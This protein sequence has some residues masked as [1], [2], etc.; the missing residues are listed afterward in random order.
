MKVLGSLAN[1]NVVIAL[2]A[3]SLAYATGVYAGFAVR[4][5]VL[6]LAFAATWLVYTLDRL[7]P[8]SP[9]DAINAPARTAFVARW[10]PLLLGIAVTSALA[11][12]ASVPFLSRSA[13]AVGAALAGVVLVYAAP[14]VPTR[15][16]W[17]RGKD[18]GVTKPVLVALAWSVGTVIVPALDVG[19][20]VDAVLAFVTFYR[21]LFVLAATL[22]FELRDV[23]GDKS[24]FPHVVGVDA[25]LRIARACL[26]IAGVSAT[27]GVFIAGKTAWLL[28]A[29]C[30]VPVLLVLLS[31]KE[32]LR[33]E[34]HLGVWVDGALALPGAAAFLLHVSGV[35]FS[36][37]G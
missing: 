25:T 8:F 16:G 7:A 2:S 10:R 35:D 11:C 31:K 26:V 20:S 37:V 24:G 23:D 12:A 32:R 27:A 33:D 22:A 3:L 36:R 14:I 5:P 9:E 28:L 15:A 1:A 18:F 4:W 30:V 29:V 34:S 19:R 17:R 21:F 6:V 13:L